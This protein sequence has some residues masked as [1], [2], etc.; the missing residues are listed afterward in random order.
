MKIEISSMR[1]VFLMSLCLLFFE[2]DFGQE[3]TFQNAKIIWSPPGKEF[4]VEV[5]ESLKDIKDWQD[6]DFDSRYTSVK[7]YETEKDD[8]L[9]RV[10]VVGLDSKS[11]KLSSKKKF[12]LLVDFLNG[13]IDAHYPVK[14]FK[15]DGISAM[16]VKIDL[17]HGRYRMFDGGNTIFMIGLI[18]KDVKDLDAGFANRFFTSFHLLKRKKK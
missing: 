9:F 18:T 4:A 10:F 15:Y 12:A 8:C 7:S 1:I 16:E 13:D 17:W 2:L 5:P 6:D 3:C 14:Y 11:S